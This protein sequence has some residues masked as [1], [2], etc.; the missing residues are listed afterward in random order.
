MAMLLVLD[1]PW[2]S[3]QSYARPR[4][5]VNPQDH[6]ADRITLSER[7]HNMEL[8]D[9]VAFFVNVEKPLGTQP[10]RC[11]PRPVLPSFVRLD[12]QQS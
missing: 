12:T 5:S 9:V 2:S 3:G 8:H 4:E 11:G 1:G 10:M 7:L 6:F